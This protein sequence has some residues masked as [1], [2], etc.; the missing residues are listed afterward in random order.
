MI[1]QSPVCVRVREPARGGNTLT[2][3]YKKKKDDKKNISRDNASK[4]NYTVV[5]RKSDHHRLIQCMT[6]I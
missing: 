4:S 2:K 6:S 5:D 1:R 3:C